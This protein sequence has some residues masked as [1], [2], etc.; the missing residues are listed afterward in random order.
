MGR[1][2][3][4]SASS[5]KKSKEDSNPCIN[6]DGGDDR[7]S[8]IWVNKINRGVK[9][10]KKL[11]T[12]AIMCVIL[13]LTS[14]INYDV[15]DCYYERHFDGKSRYQGYSRVCSHGS[16]HYDEHSKLKGWTR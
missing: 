15:S 13:L 9:M 4:S 1:L 5:Y 2:Y 14:C 11:L 3:T 6:Y 8:W 12:Y 7:I 10:I 16:T